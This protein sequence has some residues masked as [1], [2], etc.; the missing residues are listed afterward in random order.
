LDIVARAKEAKLLSKAKFKTA[1]RYEKE[2]FGL[3][4]SNELPKLALDAINP[5]MRLNAY[6][7]R[8]PHNSILA[9]QSVESF[10]RVGFEKLSKCAFHTEES[11][12]HAMA[13]NCADSFLIL[14]AY[15]KEC[16]IKPKFSKDEQGN[17]NGAELVEDYEPTMNLRLCFGADYGSFNQLNPIKRLSER[18][19]DIQDVTAWFKDGMM[20][21]DY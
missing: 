10:Y 15:I 2:S 5:L 4:R 12:A 18:Y 14:V 17:I 13:A 9:Y 8:F 16:C 6:L 19:G 21:R 20:L 1:R 7:K 3:I 11:L